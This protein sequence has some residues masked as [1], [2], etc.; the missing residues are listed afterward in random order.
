MENCRNYSN[1]RSTRKCAE[2]FLYQSQENW[3]FSCFVEEEWIENSDR[4]REQLFIPLRY[5]MMKYKAGRKAHKE[6]HFKIRSRDL[7]QCE[8]ERVV[9]L[10]WAALCSPCGESLQTL[11]EIG[12]DEWK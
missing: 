7:N 8:R 9:P 1:K 4:G 11:S 6:D 2:G 10:F 12:W 5:K 3:H